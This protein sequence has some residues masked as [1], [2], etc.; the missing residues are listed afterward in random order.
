MTR[1]STIMGATVGPQVVRCSRL[2]LGIGEGGIGARPGRAG[3][4][5]IGDELA[6]LVTAD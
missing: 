1:L 6:V 2:D 4:D 5:G 3:S